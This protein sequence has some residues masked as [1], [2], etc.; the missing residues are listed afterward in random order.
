MDTIDN[1]PINT[2]VY[3]NIP[4]DDLE[5]DNGYKVNNID[6]VNENSVTNEQIQEIANDDINIITIY[7][8]N[9]LNGIANDA[10]SLSRPY[11]ERCRVFIIEYFLPLGYIIAMIVSLSF[12]LPGKVI[13][14]VTY[15][16][17]SI[18]QLLNIFC[19]FLISGIT[20]DTSSV[21][22]AGSQYKALI[23][24][25]ISIV[26]LTPMFSFGIMRIPFQPNEF[27]LGLAIFS[28]VPTTLG[29]GVALTTACNG[30]VTISLLLTIITNMLGIVYTPY[31]LDLL[32]LGSTF[33]QFNPALLFIKLLI[34]I[35]LP[36][37][38]GIALH[39]IKTIAIWVKNHKKLLSLFSSMN[40]ICIIWQ[41]L[42]ISAT[43]ILAQSMANIA[44]IIVSTSLVH[45]FTILF[46][47]GITLHYFVNLDA[48]D[49]VSVIIMGSQKSAPVAVTIISYITSNKSQQGLLIL[50]AMIGQMVQIFIG[51]ILASRFRKFIK[52]NAN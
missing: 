16:N 49:R 34:T 48:I 31:Y 14:S 21:T 17:L 1:I 47:I 51:Y 5:L 52:D 23:V 2:H 26:L 40:L 8:E 35:C 20:L 24:G 37:L 19:V 38:I 50:P 41:V 13:A 7:N 11:V 43:T 45:I 9:E 12:P 18:I 33:I 3:F 30:N 32:L 42:S 25:F 36:T 22:F 6:N 4:T 44:I 39:R 28:C 15:N 27:A 46:M 10:N 29:V